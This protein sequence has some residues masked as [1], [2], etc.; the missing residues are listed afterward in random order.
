[1]R[2]ARLRLGRAG[3]LVAAIGVGCGLLSADDGRHGQAPYST[4]RIVSRRISAVS[5][6]GIAGAPVNRDQDVRLAPD[7]RALRSSGTSSGTG[8]RNGVPPPTTTGCDRQGRR[9]RRRRPGRG[10]DRARPRRRAA[11]VHR[12]GHFSRR[13]YRL[14][15]GSDRADSCGDHRQPHSELSR[16]SNDSCECR[17]TP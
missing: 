2:A 11:H 6:R 14:R 13:E 8:G 16:V 4:A 5:V 9:D 3:E 15:L 1:M 17:R 7:L 12:A 10:G